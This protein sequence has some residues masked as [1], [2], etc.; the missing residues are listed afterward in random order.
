MARPLLPSARI[1]FGNSPSPCPVL[2]RIIVL[3]SFC[4]F[5][6]ACGGKAASIGEGIREE[7]AELGHE[8]NVAASETG[9][10]AKAAGEDVVDMA[11][12]EDTT[13]LHELSGTNS[14][15]NQQEHVRQMA[16]LCATREENIGALRKKG[17]SW[18]AIAG[19]YGLKT[20]GQSVWRVWDNNPPVPDWQARQ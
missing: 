5:L 18:D 2:A 15:Q 6:S 12:G 1:C 20:G 16:A 10:V 4:L 3:L 8:I 11:K 17:W 13:D 14:P 19:K 9:R 7:A